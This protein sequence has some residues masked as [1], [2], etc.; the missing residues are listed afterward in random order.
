M[1]DELMKFDLPL[2]FKQML[3]DRDAELVSELQEYMCESAL[4]PALKH[5][6]VFD[7]PMTMP[8]R[9]NRVLLQKQ[10]ALNEAIEEGDWHTAVFLHE[11]PYR[12]WAL[13]ELLIGRDEEGNVLSIS[14]RPQEVLDLVSDV[15]VDSENIEQHLDDWTAMFDGPGWLLGSVDE[16]EEF[17]QLS[18]PLRVYR[19][20][21]E[22]GGWSWSVELETAKFFAGR[23]DAKQNIVIAEVKKEDVFGYLSRRN[24]YEVLVREDAEINVVGVLPYEEWKGM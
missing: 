1:N 20:E 15:W 5:P 21:I 19:G 22:D 6:L 8:G 13:I 7:V 10:E 18:D 11:R 12:C 2:Q 23:W 3:E 24:E 17:A 9:D 14:G 16:Q 4:G